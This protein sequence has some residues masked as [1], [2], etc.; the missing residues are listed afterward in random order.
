ME[1]KVISRGVV[2]YR[3]NKRHVNH[4]QPVNHMT[5]LNISHVIYI[6]EA[7]LGMES[8]LV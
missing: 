6:L 5:V 8:L 4:N 3:S 7:S 1:D 2:P